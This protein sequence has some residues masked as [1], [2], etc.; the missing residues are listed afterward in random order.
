MILETEHFFSYVRD[1]FLFN[2]NTVEDRYN[3]HSNENLISRNEQ[4]FLLI[5]AVTEADADVAI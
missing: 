2:Y 5:T 1:S 4:I 3:K